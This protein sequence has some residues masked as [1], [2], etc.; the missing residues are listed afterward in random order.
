MADEAASS[1]TTLAIDIGGTGIKMLV[2][3]AEGRALTERM[4]ELTPHPAAPEAVLAV[5]RDMVARQPAF[6]RVAVG[7]PGVV[8]RGVVKTAPNLDTE[9][10]REQD[11]EAAIGGITG[12]PTRVIND[13]DLQGYGV[14]SGH[15]VEL[16]LTLGTGLGSGLYVDGHLVPN[17][18]LAHH[19]F[20]KGRTYE[21]RMS[22]AELSRI[23]KKKWNRRIARILTTLRPIFNFDKLYL[24]GG[25]AKKLRIL[26]P[27]GVEVFENVEG[28]AGGVR[29][30]GD[31]RVT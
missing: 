4:R 10:W 2:I 17:L 12:R 14:I 23:G 3:D 16:V 1:P 26:L 21:E 28:M 19:P 30:W 18:E 27:E 24:G 5:I 25:N 31:R 8:V 6:E 7:F 11:L 13:A 22:D 29:L 9:L 20:E 15:G